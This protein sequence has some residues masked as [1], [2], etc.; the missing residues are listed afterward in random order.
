MAGHSE[1]NEQSFSAEDEVLSPLPMTPKR[2]KSC[3]FLVDSLQAVVQADTMAKEIAQEQYDTQSSE[4]KESKIAPW[5][6]HVELY[7]MDMMTGDL[8]GKNVIDLA[9]G[10]GHYSRW[11]KLSKGAD[12]VL[13]V[14]LSQGMIDL[15]LSEEQ[16]RPLGIEYVCCD[17]A[18]VGEHAKGYD[19][20]IAAYLLNY[21]SSYEELL[22]FCQAIYAALPAGGM[23]Y[24]MNNS[25]NDTVLHHP[26]LRKYMFTKTCEEPKEGATVHYTFYNEKEELLCTIDNY[27]LSRK[28]YD[29]AFRAAGFRLFGYMS[30]NVS[31]AGKATAPEAYWDELLDAQP[32][33]GIYA[34]K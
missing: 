8:R 27:A 33:E 19:V 9:C 29:R 16:E 21:A 24:S 22:G 12:R 20:I 30:L 1:L 3:P 25:P 17:A 31:P 4:Y 18:K 28:T 26:Q 15:A 32:V 11:L 34:R 7:T 6:E 23:F 2:K 10:D 14:D 13:G 5:R